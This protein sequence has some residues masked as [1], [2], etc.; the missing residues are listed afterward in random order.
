MTQQQQQRHDTRYVA[1]ETV[2]LLGA[3]ADSKNKRRDVARV[4]AEALASTQS[5]ALTDWDAVNDAIQA[6]WSR[7]GLIYIKRLAWAEVLS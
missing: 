5:Y 3:V 6:R 1:R 4:Y 2:R 7:H